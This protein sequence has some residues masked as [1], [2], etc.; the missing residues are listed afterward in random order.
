MPV[1]LFFCATV[2]DSFL[3]ISSGKLPLPGRSH[4]ARRLLPQGTATPKP[5]LTDSLQVDGYVMPHVA[6]YPFHK[7]PKLVCHRTGFFL[8]SSDPC[9]PLMLCRGRTRS[10]RSLAPRPSWPFRPPVAAVAFS[11]LSW[12][13]ERPARY[14]P[15]SLLEALKDTEHCAS[16][17]LPS[18]PQ[19][20]DLG[21]TFCLNHLPARPCKRHTKYLR[22]GLK[23]NGHVLARIGRDT[24]WHKPGT[25]RTRAPPF[26]VFQLGQRAR[27][28]GSSPS[29]DR[30]GD[31]IE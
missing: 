12:S 28:E 5:N 13:C 27:A 25:Y 21:T 18:P 2:T 15:Y 14:G 23:A 6:A 1:R 16:L 7:T 9:V 3:H 31:S 24:I 11:V 17:G 29:D 30:E 10:R 22:R 19:C 4:P 20:P 8:A 26:D